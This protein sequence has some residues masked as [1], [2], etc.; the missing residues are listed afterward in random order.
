[1]KNYEKIENKKIVCKTNLGSGS[2]LCGG[3]VLAPPQSPS[4]ESTFNQINKMSAVI[5]NVIFSKIITIMMQ[6]KTNKK[7]K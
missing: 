6:L 5:Q 7:Y 2:R 3:K 4:Y 1:M